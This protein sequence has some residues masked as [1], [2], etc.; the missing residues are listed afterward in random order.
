MNWR[1]RA[2]LLTID[3]FYWLMTIERLLGHV[4]RGWIYI[5]RFDLDAMIVTSNNHKYD[6]FCIVC[7]N[8][9]FLFFILLQIISTSTT[10]WFQDLKI[11]IDCY[12][13]WCEHRLL[14]YYMFL[15]VYEKNSLSMQFNKKKQNCQ[16]LSLE[17]V[18]RQLPDQSKSE[19][20]RR[21]TNCATE[22]CARF[23]YLC[24][25]ILRRCIFL[26]VFLPARSDFQLFCHN[27]L[28]GHP[29]SK[30]KVVM[31]SSRPALSNDV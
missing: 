15:L 29:F 17:L 21:S 12:N 27:F 26:R 6:L 28:Q 30:I 18:G 1:A 2:L 23:D 24:K 20:D 16:S 13:V 25:V 10:I 19:L 7:P 5:L 8:V 11:D 4:H 3:R 22:A 14:W 9:K 31:R